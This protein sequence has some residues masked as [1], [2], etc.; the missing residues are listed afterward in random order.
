MVLIYFWAF[1]SVPLIYMFV[2]VQVP[3]CFDYCSF[4]IY[5]EVRE[6]NSSSSVLLHQDCF[7]Y[8]GSFVF[9]CKFKKY[10]FQFC[11]KY[12]WYFDKD[13]IESV[14][15]LGQFFCFNNI[16]FFSNPRMWYIFLFVSSNFF[17]Q[18][19]TVFGVLLFCCFRQ[20]CFY[21]F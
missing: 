18:C 8:S 17:H 16:D 20:V 13:C 7:D 19:L 1:C 4:V 9:L 14:D 10:L 2:F 5:S 6:N 3:Y 12:H 15:Y 11:E 21:S